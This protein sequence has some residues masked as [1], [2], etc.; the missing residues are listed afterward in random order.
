M[1]LPRTPAHHT[2]CIPNPGPRTPEPACICTRRVTHTHEPVCGTPVQDWTPCSFPSPLPHLRQHVVD[3]TELRCRKAGK[4]AAC[5][6]PTPPWLPHA[7]YPTSLPHSPAP[8][9]SR[10]ARSCAALCGVPGPPPASARWGS[11]T[12]P[13]TRTPATSG[14]THGCRQGT[15]CMRHFEC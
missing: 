13:Q 12:A 9:C 5:C 1:G 11:T 7:P 10:R 6:H 4:P 14:R 8:A 3:C 15:F 2:C